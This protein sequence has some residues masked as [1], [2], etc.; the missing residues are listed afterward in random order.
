MKS[1]VLLYPVLDFSYAIHVEST[2][3]QVQRYPSLF[4]YSYY[5]LPIIII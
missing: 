5:I 4:Y 2:L 3:E 1:S